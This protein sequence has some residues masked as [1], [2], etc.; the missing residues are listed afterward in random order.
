MSRTS[1]ARPGR[2]LAGALSVLALGAC[3]VLSPTATPP[4]AFYSLDSAP[5]T[6]PAPARAAA[7]TLIINPPRAAA[8]FDSQRIIYVRENHKLE[9]FAHSEWVDPPAR[10]LGPLLVAAIEHTGAFTAVVLTPGAAG[11]DLRLDTEIVRL[12]HE[13]QTSPSRVRLTLRAY[14]IDD[15][16][17]RV[18]A[19]RQFDAA[20]DA[21][22]DDPYGGVLAANSAVQTVLQQL[23]AFCAETVA[24][25]H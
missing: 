7:P 6:A 13:F 21:A 12:Q 2:L 5:V 20:V 23:S 18:L 14:L 3:S 8:G 25:A 9:Y 11:G 17:R 24:S 10:M 15:K 1:F 22:S 4:P 19:W 16:T